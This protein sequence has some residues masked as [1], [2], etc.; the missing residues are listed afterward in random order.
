MD[1]R[2]I[3]F[4][5]WE[6]P[7]FYITFI[8]LFIWWF[9][10]FFGLFRAAP[11]AYGGSQAKHSKSAKFKHGEVFLFTILLTKDVVFFQIVTNSA[12]LWVPNN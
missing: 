8:Y 11:V 2:Q 9:S 3:H 4:H 10:F 7:L 1:T 6:L 12:V 5:C